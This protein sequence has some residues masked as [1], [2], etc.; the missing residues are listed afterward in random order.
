MLC[1]V[2]TCFAIRILLLVLTLDATAFAQAVPPAQGAGSGTAPL[3]P[4]AEDGV[5]ERAFPYL[6]PT[7]VPRFAPPPRRYTPPDGFAGHQWGELRSTFSRLPEKPAAV[8]A[9]WTHGMRVGNEVVCTGR[10]VQLCTVED[11]INSQRSWLFEGDGFHVLSEYL[12]ES[13]GF[14]FSESGV[15][16]HPVVYEFCANWHG[17]RSKV[18]EKFER[19][20]EFC[21]MRLLFETETQAQLRKLPGDHVTRYD[22]VLA[23]L[24]ARYG[25]PAN[26]TWRGKVTVET[27]DGP[28]VFTPSADRKFSTWRWCP[29]P[30]DGLMTRCKASIVLSVDPDAGRGIVLFSTPAMW[31]Y[32]FARESSEDAAPDALFTLMHALSFK[33][34]HAQAQR[35]EAAWKAAEAKKVARRAADA[36][37]ASAAQPIDAKPIEAAP[38]SNA[39]TISATGT[40]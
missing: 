12:I 9:A 6:A 7:D 19:L 27:V 37:V 15:L 4:P 11:F 33:H 20:N 2:R 36:P 28:A 21:G 32:A 3:E 35:K 18:P 23:E 10:G 1:A 16:L 13:Q 26:F 30:R 31:Q 17:M 14:R 40:P 8:R 38:A 24:I 25:K 39:A 5:V 22:L 34:R 29:A